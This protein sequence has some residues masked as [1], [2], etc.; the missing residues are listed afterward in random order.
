MDGK[1]LD[2]KAPNEKEEKSLE[3]LE[4]YIGLVEKGTLFPTRADMLGAGVTRDQIRHHF[5]NIARLRAAAKEEFPDTFKGVLDVKELTSKPY[6]A[7]LNKIVRKY[8][9]F[10]ISTAISGQKVHSEFLE[11][12]ENYCS[13]NNAKLLLIP[14]HDPAHNLDNEIEWHMDDTLVDFDWVFEKLDLNSNVHISEIRVTAKQINPT[15]GLG[16]FVQELGSAIFGSSKQSLE[17]VPVSKIKYPHALMSTGAI[18][19]PNYK[20]SKGNSLRT[21]YI[22][23]HDHKIGALIVE[24]QDD[25]I[26]HFRQIQADEKGGFC[27]IGKYYLKNS[28]KNVRSK[29]VIGD[30]HSGQ[31]DESA[32]RAWLELCKEAHVDEVILHDLH[33]GLATNHHDAHKMVTQAK[34]AALGLL[35]AKKELG[36]TGSVLN[37]WTTAVDKVTVTKSNHDEFLERWLEEARFAKDPYNFQLGCKLADA[38]VDGKDPLIE[39]VTLYGNLKHPKR[40]NWLK[41]DQDYRIFGHENGAHGDV[42]PGGSKGT[43]IGLEKSYFSATIAHSHTAGILREVFQVGTTSWFDLDYNRGASSWMHCSCLEYDNGNRQLINSIRGEYRLK[44]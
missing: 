40:I 22:A 27:D 31:H 36:I 42:G 34:R 20:T 9:R 6:L 7:N 1:N 15:T 12:I 24:I 13:R 44:E 11:S 25:K 14:C 16:R 38:M 21:A 35:D 23:H 43:K 33:N 26:Y 10:V 41:R 19:L 2:G 28:I 8:K 32:E 4:A 39:G 37:R 17:F 30:Y 18:S 29:L 5:I 3:I